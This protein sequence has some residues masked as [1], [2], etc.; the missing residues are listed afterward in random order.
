MATQNAYGTAAPRD[1][2]RHQVQLMLCRN[3]DGTAI[4]GPGGPEGGTFYIPP[5]GGWG[6]GTLILESEHAQSNTKTDI[7]C[8]EA[9]L[10]PEYVAGADVNLVV[11]AKYAG[12]G[13]AGIVTIDA[14]VYE[15]DDEGAAAAIRAS[16]TKVLTNAFADHTFDDITETNLAPGDKLMVLIRTVIQETGGANDLYAQIGNVE[17]QID[18]KG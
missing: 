11:H 17:L 18:I 5:G 14:E 9:V 4:A 16:S 2:S 3:E 15:L 13:T 6:S 12:A 8:F 10:P 7:F 1:L